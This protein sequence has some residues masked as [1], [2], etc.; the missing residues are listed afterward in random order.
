MPCEYASSP[1]EV[2]DSLNVIL[3]APF[4]PVV[5][6]TNAS[7]IALPLSISIT[8]VILVPLDVVSNFLLPSWYSSTEPFKLNFARVSLAEFVNSGELV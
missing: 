3:E 5:F 8:P 7:S 6:I 4:V 2:P 1:F